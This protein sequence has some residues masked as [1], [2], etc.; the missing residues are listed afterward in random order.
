MEAYFL[1][2]IIFFQ[3]FQVAIVILFDIYQ[4][5]TVKKRATTSSII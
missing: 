2:F 1:P 4:V 3:L 5:C